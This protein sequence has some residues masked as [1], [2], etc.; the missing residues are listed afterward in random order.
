MLINAFGIDPEY[1]HAPK[2]QRL[3]RQQHLLRNLVPRRVPLQPNNSI[4]SPHYVDICFVV[5]R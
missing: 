3:K 4:V 2:C 5:V 1:G